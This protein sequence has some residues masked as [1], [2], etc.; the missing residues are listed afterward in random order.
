[1]PNS[2]VLSEFVR[3][4]HQS[5]PIEKAGADHYPC[6]AVAPSKDE[7]TDRDSYSADERID[8]EY[9]VLVCTK[10]VGLC[11]DNDIYDHVK[12]QNPERKRVK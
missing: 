1:M 7:G 4:P 12:Q 11:R 8:E 9:L 5:A 3:R 2:S 10:I 6:G